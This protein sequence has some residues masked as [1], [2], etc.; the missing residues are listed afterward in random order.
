MRLYEAYAFEHKN[1]APDNSIFTWTW[2]GTG[3]VENSQDV[4]NL[5]WRGVVF[6]KESQF[7]LDDSSCKALHTC[8]KSGDASI[9]TCDYEKPE[10]YM[11]KISGTFEITDVL[12]TG[13]NSEGIMNIWVA[14]NDAPYQ[15]ADACDL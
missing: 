4:Y 5:P 6:E 11:A 7:T 13:N 14:G 8:F 1:Y 3:P 15:P 10:L 2:A 12:T 9:K